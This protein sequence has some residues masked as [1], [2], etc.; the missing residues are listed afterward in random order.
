MNK[1]IRLSK[2]NI[3]I[4]KIFLYYLDIKKAV[5]DV[6][7]ERESLIAACAGGT[8][9]GG[10]GKVY[11]ISKPVERKVEMLME[12]I[13][14]IVFKNHDALEEVL[15]NPIEWIKAVDKTLEHFSAYDKLISEILIERFFDKKSVYSSCEKH[16]IDKNTY[17]RLVD[18][19]IQYA[20]EC[21]IQLGL[22]KVF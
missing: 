11:E 5:E 19:G 13:K 20:K 7:E 21:A 6:L 15:D 22:I 9:V 3:L 18:E 14:R 17:Y 4:Q 12:P 2:E 10:G 16:F 8:Y 1:H